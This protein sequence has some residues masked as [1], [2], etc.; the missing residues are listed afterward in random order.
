MIGRSKLHWTLERAPVPTPEIRTRRVCRFAERAQRSARRLRLADVVVHQHELAELPMVDGWIGS[1]ASVAQ[2]RGLGRRIRIEGRVG[3]FAAAG[4]E[5]HAA[6]FVRVRFA[7]YRIGTRTLG[8]ASSGESRDGEVE[9][10]PEEMDVT[11]LAD[12]AGAKRVE[13]AIN[14]DQDAAEARHGVAVVAGVDGVVL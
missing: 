1:H 4:P 14:G 7:R 6:D 11:A 2:A 10:A 3:D 13:H 5:A 8:G 12:E 9:A